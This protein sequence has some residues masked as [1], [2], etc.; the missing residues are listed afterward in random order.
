MSYDGWPPNLQSFS[1]NSPV[2]FGG[3]IDLVW[4]PKNVEARVLKS[5]ANSVAEF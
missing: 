3:R 4:W 1:L 5:A 2:K